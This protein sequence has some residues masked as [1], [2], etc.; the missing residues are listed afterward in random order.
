MAPHSAHYPVLSLPFT[1]YI[2]QATQFH[3]MNHYV[4]EEEWMQI[5]VCLDHLSFF[6]SIT[7]TI[8][9]SQGFL[10]DF[11]FTQKKDL[12]ELPC[13]IGKSPSYRAPHVSITAHFSSNE[14]RVGNY[15]TSTL[16]SIVFTRS[17]T[18]GRRP[19]SACDTFISAQS[20]DALAYTTHT[21]ITYVFKSFQT[22]LPA[23]SD[24]SIF[25][26][27]PK[28]AASQCKATKVHQQRGVDYDRR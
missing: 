23:R 15:G 27:P 22:T 6:P 28:L 12:F 19:L 21:T 16:K 20:L 5:P 1:D 4:D 7:T 3:R 2:A 8:G 17:R 10:T 24:T 11:G 9:I 13:H 14:C 26:R 25:S 18:G